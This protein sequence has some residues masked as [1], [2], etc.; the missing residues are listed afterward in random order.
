[1]FGNHRSRQQYRFR[2]RR[3][4]SV[5]KPMKWWSKWS[6]RIANCPSVYSCYCQP[7]LQGWKKTTVQIAATAAPS[8]AAGNVAPDSAA[9]CAAGDV[10]LALPA[11][12]TTQKWH[13]SKL[14]IQANY[15]FIHSVQRKSVSSRKRKTDG[16]GGEYT[17]R[18]GR[19]R[20]V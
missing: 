12:T 18:G 15:L 8:S 14:N 10:G 4:R 5:T 9:P 11:S 1:M 20:Q 7:K 2:R 6:T 17:Q 19:E 3:M 13:K 16:V